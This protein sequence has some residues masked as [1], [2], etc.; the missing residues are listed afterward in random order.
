[1]GAITEKSPVLEVSDLH[2]NRLNSVAIENAN[3]TIHQGDYVGIVGPNGGGK[4][5]LLLAILNIIPHT[6]GTIRLFGQNTESFTS[7]E[8]VAYVPQNATN[9]DSQFP[10]TV[11][12][13]VALGRV[14]PQPSA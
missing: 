11:R 8:K 6:E 5:T 2:V 13:L 7:W 10:L 4:T 14:T 1:M 9:F 12:E 3:F